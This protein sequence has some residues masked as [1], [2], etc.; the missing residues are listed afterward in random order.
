MIHELSKQKRILEMG[1]CLSLSVFLFSLHFS[2]PEKGLGMR[3]EIWSTEC[4]S[5]S[6][7]CSKLV[8]EMLNKHKFIGMCQESICVVYNFVFSFLYIL[9]FRADFLAHF[10]VSLFSPIT[11]I[12]MYG[13][14]VSV[15]IIQTH[16]AKHH[17]PSEINPFLL[18]A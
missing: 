10:G 16:H 14:F 12:C 5:G 8:R 9:N 3:W 11:R 1:L 7:R 4:F 17:H 2:N 13:Y 15:N 18:S 6:F